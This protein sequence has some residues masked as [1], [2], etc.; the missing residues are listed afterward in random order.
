ML[1][2]SFFGDKFVT[3]ISIHI[4]RTF[5]GSPAC[6]KMRAGTSWDALVCFQFEGANYQPKQDRNMDSELD[7]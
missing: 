1:A 2:A 5:S 6:A 3:R 4:A 7:I